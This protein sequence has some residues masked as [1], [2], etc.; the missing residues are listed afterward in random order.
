MID[1][2]NANSIDV[3][4][5]IDHHLATTAANTQAVTA[6]SCTIEEEMC[7]MCGTSQARYMLLHPSAANLV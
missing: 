1:V 5:M 3:M 7:E 2:W 6:N 4:Y